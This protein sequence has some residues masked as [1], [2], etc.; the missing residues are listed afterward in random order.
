MEGEKRSGF[1]LKEEFFWRRVCERE[2][3]VEKGAWERG[4]RT[5]SGFHNFMRER[6]D[7]DDSEVY[8]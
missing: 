4:D 1:G 5:I 2:G 3:S 7:N 8:F 6:A